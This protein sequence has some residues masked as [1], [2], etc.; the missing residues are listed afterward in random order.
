MW[1]ALVAAACAQRTPVVASPKPPAPTLARLNASK[2][3]PHA[4]GKR[5]DVVVDCGKSHWTFSTTSSQ[6]GQRPLRGAL[7][8]VSETGADAPDP[9]L[10]FRVGILAI[11]G[12]YKPLVADEV[13]AF[14]CDA[15]HV[16]ARVKGTIDGARVESIACPDGPDQISV[17]TRAQSL[18]SGATLADEMNPGTAPVLVR[19]QGKNWEGEKLTDYVILAEHGS[20]LTLTGVPFQARRRL[21]HI[22]G[23]SFPAPLVLKHEGS[24]VVRTLRLGRGD[25]FDALSR[26]T[27][28]RERIALR[29]APSGTFW[30]YD[31][32]GALLAEGHLPES[33]FRTLLFPRDF[34]A[35][36]DVW[37]RFGIS[38]GPRI[39]LS[40][41]K[42]TLAELRTPPHGTLALETKDEQGRDL[43]VHMLLRGKEGTPDPSPENPDGG[44]HEG[45]SVYF[46]HGKGSVTLGPGKYEVVLTHGPTH[47]LYKRTVD[48]RADETVSLA[49]ALS[50]VVHTDEWISADLHL[51]AQPS[52]DSTVPLAAR[53]ATL[54][55]EGVDLAIATDHN[56]ITDY[57]SA[58]QE[59]KL[60]DRLG[61][62]IGDEITSAG[63]A[64][65]GHFNAFPL[66]AVP[67][68][69][70]IPYFGIAPAEM[71]TAARARGAKVIQVNHG[72]MQP[73]IGYFDLM[74]LQPE[75]GAAD[76]EF[77]S[78]F[79]A[80]EAHNG[81]YMEEPERAREAMFDVVA[82]VRRGMRP[83][84]TGNSDSHRMLYEE[85]GYPRTYVYG[86][87][88]PVSGREDRLL[89]GLGARHTTV[90]A[91]PFVEAWIVRAGGRVPIGGTFVPQTDGKVTLHVRVSAPGWVPVE[92][93]SVWIDDKAVQTF[94]FL[95]DGKDGVRFE[96]D[97]EL[98]LRRDAVLW[99][100]ASADTPLPDV[101]PQVHAKPIGFTGLFY[102]DAD[103]DGKVTLGPR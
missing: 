61:T 1:P 41:L 89:A 3:A 95:N 79:D 67:D 96:K 33:G 16:G 50:E 72:R 59:A 25:A 45:R 103:G 23:E 40:S 76:P 52:P 92:N 75:T 18:P 48:I 8:D 17:R 69:P 84:V 51:H 46:T 85:A 91:G 54:A 7:L 58:V 80:V 27:G 38:T 14:A 9:L 74:H 30:L 22:S 82:L 56:H 102:V 94:S 100:W 81:L 101:L 68:E 99:A 73:R 31:D 44:F 11:D 71:F 70:P 53:V 77:S 63:T 15:V 6:R 57:G 5:G 12:T 64:L 90:S 60:G 65:Y 4:H 97:I 13:E 39:E 87:R 88:M 66:K 2:L 36:L 37:D 55:C 83:A 34:G 24:E 47:T 10:W 43:S 49:A 28:T 98:V 78:D 86:A 62:V 35:S 93:A 26:V 29:G 32:K 20:T 19:G 42:A 21:V